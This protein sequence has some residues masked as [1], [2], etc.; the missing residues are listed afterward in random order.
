MFHEMFTCNNLLRII[1][2]K[3]EPVKIS[4]QR[5]ISIENYYSSVNNLFFK[6]QMESKISATNCHGEFSVVISQLW[7]F[8]EK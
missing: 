8:H 7:L 4:P 3:Y 6:G 2:I 5:L 1:L